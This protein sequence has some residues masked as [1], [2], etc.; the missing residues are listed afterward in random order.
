MALLDGKVAL[1][2][3]GGA[4]IGRGVVTSFVAEGAKVVVA[5]YDA[6]RCADLRAEHHDVV[7]V[8]ADVREKAQVLAAVEAAASAFGGL[9]I[10]VNNAITLSP[11]LPLEQKTDEML[12]GTLHSG[13]W[14]AWWAM[15]AVLP[16]MAARGGG[17][18]V[19]FTSIDV[20][21]GNWLNG[22]YIV[23]KSAVQGLT[24]SAAHEW[25]RYGIRV[26]AVAPAAMGTAFARY[27]AEDPG[28]AARSAA[29]KPLGR[30]GDPEHDIAPAVVFLASEMSRFITGELL[31]VDGGL[32]IPGYQSRP[33]DLAAFDGG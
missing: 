21:T 25:G 31:H 18:I 2:T 17:S 32:H 12:D 8:P 24:R 13:L 29:L 9:D 30:N 5:E 28:F 7:V 19:N 14:A 22:D 10:L 23:A 1:V 3:G 6:E 11:R 33:A 15:R 4:G 20:Q 16:L 27:A 26:N